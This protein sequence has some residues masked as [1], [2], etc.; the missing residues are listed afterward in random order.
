MDKRLLSEM[1][2]AYY[3][4]EM[5]RSQIVS[6]LFHRIFKLESG[7]YSGHYHKDDG[8]Q[9]IRESYPIPVIGVKGLCDIEIQFDKLFVT[10]KLKRDVA[11]DY[12]FKKFSAY[13]FEAYGV[14]DYL[15]DFFHPGQTIEQMKE[16]IEACEETEIGFSF[17]FPFGVEGKQLFEFIKRL[18]HEGFYY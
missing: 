2:A 14:E 3:R 8:G 10:T 13:E 4:L 15:A 5:K 16:N 11:L 9:W 6:A 1:N 7:W 17:V 12:S 18:R